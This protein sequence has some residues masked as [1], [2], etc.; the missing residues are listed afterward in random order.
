[1]KFTHA[2]LV[3]PTRRI[4]FGP[5]LNVDT[6][7]PCARPVRPAW[8]GASPRA[9]HPASSRYALGVS[10]GSGLFFLRPGVGL[11]RTTIHVTAAASVITHAMKTTMPSTPKMLSI[12]EVG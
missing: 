7:M 8:S 10:T 6:A 12:T 1:M 3:A 4:S 2:W 9:R 11:T 5:G